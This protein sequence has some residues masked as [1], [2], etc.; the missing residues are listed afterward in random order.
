MYAEFSQCGLYVWFLIR[1]D[2][3]AKGGIWMVDCESKT[4]EVVARIKA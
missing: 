4:S 3:C 1:I 2:V